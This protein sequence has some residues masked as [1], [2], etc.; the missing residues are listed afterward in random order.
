MLHEFRKATPSCTP[1]AAGLSNPEEDM[2]TFPAQIFVYQLDEIDGVAVYS[3]A[4]DLGEISDD[5]DDEKVGV[6]KL[7]REQLLKVYRELK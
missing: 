4:V 3:V 1:C 5:Q 7:V 6:Y 2:M